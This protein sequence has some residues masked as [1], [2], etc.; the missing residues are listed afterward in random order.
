MAYRYRGPSANLLLE[1]GGKVYHPGDSVPI[2]KEM[3]MHLSL[4]TSGGHV[5]DGID[6]PTPADVAT[7]EA[8]AA[9]AEA[10]PAVHPAAPAKGT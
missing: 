3:A 10:A 7:E 8:K 4:N 2:S 6:A 1:E 5:F 9:A